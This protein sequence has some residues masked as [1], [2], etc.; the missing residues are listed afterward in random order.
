VA[1]I[2]HIRIRADAGVDLTE[3]Q[4]AR[5]LLESVAFYTDRGRWWAWLFL[6]MP[7][8]LH[9]LL[10][11]PREERMSAVI[12]D[13]KR[14]HAGSHGIVWQQGY[15]DHRLRQEE[16]FAEKAAYIRANPVVK[17]LCLSAEDWPWVYAADR[18]TPA[19]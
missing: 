6:V 13:W 1:A 17:G 10:S 12:G 8:H 11:F 3:P 14:F 15:F 2:F 9:T 16:S 18:D 19:P 5:R 4:T 7:D